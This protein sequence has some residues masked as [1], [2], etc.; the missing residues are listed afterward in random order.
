MC[1]VLR[2]KEAKI[3]LYLK[4]DKSCPWANKFLFHHIRTEYIYVYMYKYSYVY[5]YSHI[6]FKH[7]L[8]FKHISSHIFPFKKGIISLQSII[9]C[10]FWNYSNNSNR[11]LEVCLIRCEVQEK[12]QENPKEENIQLQYLLEKIPHI[13]GP[14]QFMPMLSTV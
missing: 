10:S 14:T 11:K 13:S 7:A 12:C 2:L 3:F 4:R 9:F 8:K 5:V 6:N 1:H